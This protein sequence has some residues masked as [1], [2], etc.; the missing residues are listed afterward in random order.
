MPTYQR[1]TTSILASFC[2]AALLGSVPVKA[3]PAE[4][5]IS[6]EDL[7]ADKSPPL[8]TVKFV[9]KIKMGGMFGSQGDQESEN[10]ITGVMIDPKG[11]VLCSNTQMGGFTGMMRLFMG[12]AGRDISAKPTELKVLIGDDTEGLEAEFLARDTELDLAW[13]RIKEPGERKFA[14]VDFAK[15]AKPRI[16]DQLFMVR[17]MDKY[18]DRSVVVAEGRLGGVTHK[19]RELYIPSTDMSANWGMPI[20]N[21]QGRVIGVLILQMPDE[22]ASTGNPM[23]ML[24]RMSSFRDMGSLILPASEVVKATRRALAT[25]GTA[26]PKADKPEEEAP[27]NTDDPKENDNEK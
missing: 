6:F 26:K 13:I 4:A 7:M 19:P 17:R 15:S 23:S 25:A 22:D 2:L 5:P 11:L 1:H 18:F 10:E 20:Y 24:G 8:V 21:A 12:R 16:G 14:C 27:D 9:L 3:A